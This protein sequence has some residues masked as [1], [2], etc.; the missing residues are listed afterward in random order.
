MPVNN[1]KR[2]IVLRNIFLI[3]FSIVMSGLFICSFL[4]SWQNHIDLD[5]RG[6][7]FVYRH[8]DNLLFNFLS[9]SII[10]CF[11][12]LI[13][14]FSEKQFMQRNI[15]I[16]AIIIGVT[17]SL[18]GA[19]WIYVSK[20]YPQADQLLIVQFA[21]A[22]NNNN[23][24][25]L[26]KGGYV[27]NHRQ[28]LG[29]I[30]IMRLLCKIFDDNAY[31]AYQYFT[32]SSL[33]LLI[34][35]GH[36]VIKLLTLQNP[37][38]KIQI[39]YLLIMLVCVP[40]YGYVPFVYGDLTSVSF[41]MLSVW[42]FL[43]LL[44]KFSWY[45]IFLL[46]ISCGIMTQ[47]RQN[48]I[49]FIV[50]FFIVLFVKTV[51]KPSWEMIITGCFIL[52]AVLAAHFMILSIYKPY[53][54]KDSKS[55]PASLFIRMGLNNS[56]EKN[57]FGWC[58]GSNETVYELAEYNPSIANELAKQDISIY[59]KEFL[60][61]PLYAMT[62]FFM[63]INTQW[64]APMYQCL[65]MNTCFYE[66]PL[67]PKVHNIYFN[68]GYIKYENFMNY[69]QLAIYG[70]VLAFALVSL[71]KKKWLNIENHVLLIA[72]FG[73]FLF[74]L[75]WEAKARYVMPY[76][77]MMIPYGVIGLFEIVNLIEDKL[78]TAKAKGN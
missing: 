71:F 4:F 59:C 47:I 52:I 14:K 48:S 43:S 17:I 1:E 5:G 53:L 56:Y 58:D 36:N 67:P 76:F 34:L 26:S 18:V 22:F 69:Y 19:F 27:S 25:A 3:M 44:N 13:Q 75:I 29:L 7:E 55:M 40:M 15:D 28:Q 42:L 41:I 61:K 64:N 9:L 73:G 54:A 21:D 32:A 62:L 50:A 77:I 65:T 10:L 66:F 8:N 2:E 23:Y 60:R 74:S 72:V 11:A 46:C 31:K 16:L 63:K 49:I 51:N 33:F 57:R 39:L 38:H 24:A 68:N 78:K 35:S 45:K 37:K 30:T 20:T 12:F 6:G 70:G